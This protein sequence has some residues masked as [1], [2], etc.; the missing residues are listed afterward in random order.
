MPAT[1][2][3]RGQMCDPM[4]QKDQHL[5][6]L[7]IIT[8]TQSLSTRPAQSY[9]SHTGTWP[10]PATPPEPASGTSPCRERERGGAPILAAG[11][12]CCPDAACAGQAQRVCKAPVGSCQAQVE[13]TCELHELRKDMPTCV[14]A[15]NPGLTRPMGSTSRLCVMVPGCSLQLLLLPVNQH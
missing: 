5:P 8:Q 12:G 6:S 7:T 9:L 15:A 11:P 2:S 3:S 14:A 1:C 4:P 10:T 13:L